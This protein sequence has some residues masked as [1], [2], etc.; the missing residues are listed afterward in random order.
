M[1]RRKR[2]KQ[3]SKR[4]KSANL[5]VAAISPR[6]PGASVSGA[7]VLPQDAADQ[8]QCAMDLHHR[9]EIADAA[10]RYLELLDR[11]P[12]HPD[13]LHLLGVT[14]YQTGD[15]A[16]AE[17]LIRKAIAKKSDAPHFYS[18]LG[19][20]LKSQGRLEEAIG[21]YEQALRLRPDY[22]E[23]Q[24]NLAL[25]LRLANRLADAADAF[26]RALELRPAHLAAR[27]SL[28]ETLRM[29]GKCPQALELLD[30][31]LAE[32]P[33][34]AE[35]WLGK[36]GVLK[37]M[38]RLEAAVEAFREAIR[39]RPD[40]LEAFNGL[41]N[42]YKDMGQVEKAT[43]AYRRAVAL[44]PD[45]STA[46]LN[47]ANILN[48]QNALAEAVSVYQR[49]REVEPESEW[50]AAGEAK[51]LM[52]RGDFD[53]ARAL[54]APLVERGSKN[55]DVAITYGQM[56]RRFGHDAEAARLLESIL[57]GNPA[58][59]D[60]R[61]QI[62]FSLCRIYDRMEDYASAFRHAEAANG[63]RPPR[64]DAAAQRRL[65]DAMIR[66][67]HPG[68]QERLPAAVNRSPLPVFIVG[69]PRSGTSLVEQIVAS[70]PGV[71]GAG[72]LPDIFRLVNQ[73]P[74][75]VPDAPPYPFGMERMPRRVLDAMA[76]F[77]LGKIRGFSRSAKRITDKMPHNFLHLGLIRL[78]FP[79]ARILH[80]VRDPLD[81]GLSI[82]FQNFSGGLSY[83]FD[84]GSIGRYYNEYVRL[85]AHWK[86][87]LDIPLLEVS[88]EALVEDQETVSRRMIDFLGLA[89]DDRC[90]EFYNT[91]RAVGT[92]SFSQVRSPVYR[93]SLKRWRHYADFLAP[94]R[95]TLRD[96]NGN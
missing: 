91:R 24:Y 51:A 73:L 33:D 29:S 80:C 2:K 9:G 90:L 75:Q 28:A 31:I 39:C 49:A 96:G 74:R 69:M 72:E 34:H 6:R 23:A 67:F 55:H 65:V 8:L 63:L 82:Y 59:I 32:T 84:L 79:G 57:A 15:H 27:I 35:A 22:V 17:E 36:G 44:Q 47:L 78:L 42:T 37:D 93:G 10:G 48:D 77:Y 58:D 26:R 18:N 21:C 95:A 4:R 7:T 85:M 30:A 89:W 56:A 43:A 20:P 1:A 62:H 16:R 76:Q 12:D 92:A 3:S 86:R 61:R 13:L 71:F 25:T 41:G 64:Y 60:Q 70:H 5:K 87:V 68:F 88:Y 11:H 66:S 50:A 53:A 14:A 83:A 19:N 94:L 38:G 45:Y 81:T 52:K 54:I 46:L 40:Y